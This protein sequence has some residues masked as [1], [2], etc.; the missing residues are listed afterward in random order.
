MKSCRPVA[1]L[2]ENVPDVMNFGGHNVSEEVC[3]VLEELGYVCAY[4]LLNAAFYGVP[5][6][7]ERMFLIAYHRDIAETVSFPEPTSG[8][9]YCL[10]TN[11]DKPRA[12]V[13]IGHDADIEAEGLAGRS[14]FASPGGVRAAQTRIRS[15]ADE[16]VSLVAES[17]HDASFIYRLKE[18]GQGQCLGVLSQAVNADLFTVANAVQA[19]LGGGGRRPPDT[20]R[21]LHVRGVR[22]IVLPP[23]APE[24]ETLYEPW[25]SSG[26][27]LA[28]LV[29]GYSTAFFPS[30]GKRRRQ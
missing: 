26:I 30:S 24:G 17:D 25:R 9:A 20:I 8:R 3:E 28:P 13:E 27:M 10:H 21:H 18:D 29:L 15:F 4:T 7:R 1:I 5:Q 12:Q 6:T 2:M 19:K 16:T 22:T 23:D 14:N 11:S